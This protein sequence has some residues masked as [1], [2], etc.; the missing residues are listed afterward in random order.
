M[1]QPT[2]GHERNKHGANDNISALHQV[3]AW[4]RLGGKS[5]LVSVLTMSFETMCHNDLSSK[6][7]GCRRMEILNSKLLWEI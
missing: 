7:T 2:V 6:Q 4:H 3:M 5:L 1:K